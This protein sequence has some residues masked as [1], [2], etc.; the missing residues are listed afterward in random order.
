MMDKFIEV[1]RDRRNCEQLKRKETII[2]PS[3]VPRVVLPVSLYALNW[4]NYVNI[5]KCEI[6]NSKIVCCHPNIDKRT[7]ND[8]DEQKEDA[9]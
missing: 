6:N 4:I 8:N 2:E 9:L 1:W 7:N 3:I 5:T